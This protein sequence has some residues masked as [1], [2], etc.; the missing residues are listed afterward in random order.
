MTILTP[1]LTETTKSIISSAM[2][3]LSKTVILERTYLTDAT[4]SIMTGYLNGK[5]VLDQFAIELPWRNN[6]QK[7][8]CIPEGVYN[9]EKRWSQKYKD[10]YHIK[11]VEGRSWVLFHSLNI[12]FDDNPGDG[13]DEVQSEGCI[14]PALKFG[15]INNDGH[16]DGTS[17]RDALNEM[18]KHFPY[19]FTLIIKSL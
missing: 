16:T 6:E 9:V 10:H 3:N 17:S 13:K 5:K 14:G 1:I 11:D 18:F 8:S 15:D 12:V 19:K 2:N 4:T 7:I